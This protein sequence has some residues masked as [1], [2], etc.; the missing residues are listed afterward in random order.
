[1]LGKNDIAASRLAKEGFNVHSI[2]HTI[3]GEGPFAGHPAIFLRLAGC[4]LRCFWCDTDFETGRVMTTEELVEMIRIEIDRF[5]CHFVVITGGEPMLQPL[6]MII[7][8]PRMSDISFQIETAGSYWP[9][10][11]LTDG[12][13]ATPRLSIV[14][15]PKTGQI[16]PPLRSHVEYNVYWKYIVRA[17]E[18]VDDH[19]GLPI[20]STQVRGNAQK[21]FRPI[22]IGVRTHKIR[23]FVQGCDEGSVS[24]THANVQYAKT[25]AMQ[26]GYRLSL[27]THK[28]LDIE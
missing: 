17:A 1:M 28:I 13:K 23:I 21:I 15:S 9:L 22:V 7:D 8:H 27:Q 24:L 20:M 16:V 18:P 12:F 4:N 3:Q 14:C 2:F 6:K 5:D 11:G 26:Y 19:D 25:I 10:G